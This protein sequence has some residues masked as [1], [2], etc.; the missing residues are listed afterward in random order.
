M[1]EYRQRMSKDKKNQAK[2]KKQSSADIKWV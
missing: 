1:T 2:E